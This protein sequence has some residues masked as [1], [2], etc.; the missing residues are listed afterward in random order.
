MTGL[1]IQARRYSVSNIAKDIPNGRSPRT[2]ALH[3]PTTA[4][5]TPAHPQTRKLGDSEPSIY[6]PA[7]FRVAYYAIHRT[8]HQITKKW[9]AGVG[10]CS[11]IPFCFFFI[12]YF[13]GSMMMM[14]LLQPPSL[15]HRAWEVAAACMIEDFINLLPI[16][17]LQI[18]P[19]QNKQSCHHA[20]T[21]S[22]RSV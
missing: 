14:T 22:C 7:H 1:I 11:K 6:L 2:H 19:L 3:G 10:R 4:L 13:G 18:M 20:S 5:L 8:G 17:P 12:D 15:G 9:D 16:S 21:A